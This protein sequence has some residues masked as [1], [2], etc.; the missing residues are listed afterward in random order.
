MHVYS[1]YYTVYARYVIYIFFT[2]TSNPR[3]IQE[4][5]PNV[6]RQP[7]AAVLLVVR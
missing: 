4:P 7:A 1:I 5:A 3:G 6:C 2:A